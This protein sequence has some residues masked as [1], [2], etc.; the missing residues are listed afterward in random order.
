MSA[1]AIAM[2][3]TK[4]TSEVSGAAAA[5][6]LVWV[7]SRYGAW[8]TTHASTSVMTATQATTRSRRGDDR[9]SSRSAATPAPTEHSARG[10]ARPTRSSNSRGESAC[11][12]NRP[13]A[14]SPP[15]TTAAIQ[16]RRRN[17]SSTWVCPA[18]WASAV[19]NTAAR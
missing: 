2:M 1:T 19:R 15:V 16:A 4:G 7:P 17:H 9:R 18:A 13:A 8:A 10:H 11:A 12:T 5:V 6:M 14:L 3:I